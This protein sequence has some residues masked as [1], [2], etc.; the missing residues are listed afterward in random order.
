VLTLHAAR[1][2]EGAEG[3]A[4]LT[5]G[6]I[7]VSGDRIAAIGPRA[8]LT[9]RYPDARVR[10]WPG[11]LAPARVH[12]AAL[13]AAPTPRERVHALL[14]VGATAVLA[15]HVSA[16]PALREAVARNGLAVL[17]VSPRPALR[18]G[19][20]AD[21]AVFDTEGRCIATV[22]AGRLVHRRR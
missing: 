20:R 18:T 4:S 13:P 1:T 11:T 12:E 14:R 6:A 3:G 15:E 17:D 19:A 22:L 10:G 9:V 8:E 16:D 2:V 7:A 21:F 5:D